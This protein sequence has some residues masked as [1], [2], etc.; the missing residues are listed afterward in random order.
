MESQD[1][2]E[3]WLMFMDDAIHQF[4]DD[5]P[6]AVSQRLDFTPESLVPLE[7]WLLS[8]YPSAK[9][10]LQPSE[11]WTLDRVARYVGETI[12]RTLGGEWTIELDN[13]DYAY[14]RLPEIRKEGNW[15]ECPASLVTTAID[16]RRGDFMKTIVRNMR[17]R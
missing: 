17:G 14:Y 3:G 9:A 15:L 5:L 4:L 11:N 10:I 13:Q 2:F 7:E 16:R 12:R 1:D 8:K 6:P